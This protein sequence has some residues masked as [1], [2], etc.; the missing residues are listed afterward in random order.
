MNFTEVMG[1]LRK[2]GSEKTVKTYRRHGVKGEMFGVSFADLGKLKKQIKAD[3]PLAEQLWASG[4]ADAR[5][6]AA[7][8]ADP[9]TLTKSVIESWV[10]DVDYYVLADYVASAAARTPFAGEILV[11]WTKSKQEFVRQ[12]GYAMLAS[13]LKDDLGGISDEA[14]AGFLG[15][16]EKEIHTSPNRARQA[17]NNALIAIGIYRSRLTRS[18]CEAAARIGVVDVD[19][20]D[21]AC[22]TPDAAAYIAKALAR[23]K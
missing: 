6:L 4:N 8:T 16:I 20:G 15:T 2:A 12:A 21:T 11:K 1:V 18:A 13:M 17:M 22:K 23:K 5:I 14:C 9:K 3:Q 7:M 19:H 10:K